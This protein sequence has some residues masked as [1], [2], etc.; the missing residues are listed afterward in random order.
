MYLHE[1]T[2]ILDLE[3]NGWKE[4]SNQKNNN[5]PS[6][7]MKIRFQNLL[8]SKSPNTPN[9]STNHD[10]EVVDF[11]KCGNSHHALPGVFRQSHC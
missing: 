7:S 11:T 1:V 8:E 10:L 2:S 3:V 4:I 9:F 6:M 5:A